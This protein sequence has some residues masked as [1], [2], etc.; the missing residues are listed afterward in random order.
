MVQYILPESV[1]LLCF[2]VSP[3]STSF[4]TKAAS[5]SVVPTAP[6]NSTVL[7]SCFSLSLT[8]ETGSSCF[9]G[10]NF[11]CGTHSSPPVV[12]S[13]IVEMDDPL[14]STSFSSSLECIWYDQRLRS[15]NLSLGHSGSCFWSYPADYVSVTRLFC[16]KLKWSV[17]EYYL[18][19][20]DSLIHAHS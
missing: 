17:K 4:S 19:N 16:R 13:N 8:Y 20:S 3:L 2:P 7:S 6:T 10:I 9:K 11:Q 5:L 14:L 15:Y 1:L 18:C 12:G